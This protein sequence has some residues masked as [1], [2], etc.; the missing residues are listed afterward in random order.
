[1]R[2]A[3]MHQGCAARFVVITACFCGCS[4]GSSAGGTSPP[5]DASTDAEHASDARDSASSD[6]A[7]AGAITASF[8]GTYAC[9]GF[10]TQTCSAPGAATGTYVLSDSCPMTI[11]A[12]TSP[13]TIVIRHADGVSLV[14]QLTD[15]THA[16]F[17][18]TQPVSG[19]FPGPGDAGTASSYAFTNGQLFASPGT[20]QLQ[21][22]GSFQWTSG[23]S[24]EA[25][26]FSQ[27]FTGSVDGGGD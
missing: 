21:E 1:M 8:L 22:F 17:A 11:T 19:T 18:A 20:M 15:A 2:S 9:T 3:P 7:D 14:W 24:S 23:T 12:G 25:C 10:Q 4:S 16:Q 5:E 27:R 13:S 26:Q 6:V